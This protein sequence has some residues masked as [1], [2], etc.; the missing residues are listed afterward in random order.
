MSNHSGSYLINDVFQRLEKFEVF[1]FLG[2]EKT[3][4][5][6]VDII[7]RADRD[8]CNPGEI[9]EDIGPRLGICHYCL[10]PAEQFADD[11]ICID[12]KRKFDAGGPE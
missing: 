2:K 11:G 12:C 7:R 10:K 8:D 1:K 4:Q 5:L 3:Q 6:V 9:L